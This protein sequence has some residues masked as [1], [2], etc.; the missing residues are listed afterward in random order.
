MEHPEGYD[1]RWWILVVLCFSLLII[2]MDNT[3][4]NVALPT[5]VRKLKASESQLQWMVDSYTLL[6]AGLLL[7]MG[8]LGDKFGRRGAL[9][10]GLTIFG[11]GSGLS[12]FSHS[13]GQL[14]AFRAVTGTGAALI[15]PA[16]LSI[17]TNVF[18]PNER[19]RAIGIWAGISGVAIA[20]GPVIG[21]F[22]LVHY[23]WGS[24]F[25]INVP[26]CAIALV[27]GR[28]IMPSSRDPEAEPLD[29][30]GAGLSII[31]LVS[32]VYGI[33]EAPN[34]GWTSGP[35]LG[36][37]AVAA[38]VLSAFVAWELHSDHP[39]LKVSFFSNPRFTAA[40]FSITLVFFALFGSIFFLTQYL[41][42]VLGYSALQAGVRLAP[43]A[44]VLMAVAPL[45]GQL[46]ARLGTKTLVAIGMAIGAVG[47]WYLAQTTPTSGYVH[48][49]TG[50]VIIAA[51]LSLSMVPATDSIMGS[52]P[53]GKAGVGSA[54]NDTTR[55][56]GG[57]LG[58]AI[59]GTVLASRYSTAIE[60]AF[61]LLPK[62]A[63]A[64]AKSSV[65]G[66]I[67]VGQQVGGSAG[68]ALIVGAKSTFISAMGTS[69]DIAALVALG[70]AII[71]AL[72]L[73]QRPREAVPEAAE[74]PAVPE[75]VPAVPD[76]ELALV[77]S[78]AGR[79]EE[80][81]AVPQAAG[82]DYVPAE[83]EAW[84]P[85]AAARPPAAAAPPPS[86]GSVDGAHARHALEDEPSPG[87]HALDGEPPAD[88]LSGVVKEVVKEAVEEALE[89]FFSK[90]ANAF[91]L[92][93]DR[94][95]ALQHAVDELRRRVE[96]GGPPGSNGADRDGR[97]V[98]A[99]TSRTRGR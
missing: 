36:A 99:A 54:M 96:A 44:L 69:L 27:V 32:L 57:A 63:L 85:P 78:G 40:S 83:A 67:A 87:R 64:V 25:L 29:P 42:F 51:G 41:Q 17:L 47:L 35:I 37:L 53:L 97:P 93:E 39:M 80:M 89:P 31:G 98:E 48:V 11:I 50:L 79:I 21:G 14:I 24:V 2:V 86:N 38:V 19:A 30:V 16:T 52:L 61:G 6:F 18:P 1:R 95:V 74:V 22:L 26:V 91:V 34:K 55:E 94:Q 66:A 23:W 5:L 45:A 62:P 20:L 72:W 4:L 59:L 82:F 49:L 9:A 60:K 8:N 46:V 76:A 15:M 58:V 84:T 7:T 13:A 33:I 71:S 10:A 88:G 3:I 73:P 43:M 81:A 12:A 77:A 68:H 90:I 92:L 70:G 28:L 56:V 65:G 75:A